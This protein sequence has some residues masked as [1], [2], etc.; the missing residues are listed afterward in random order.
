MGT[1]RLASGIDVEDTL[2]SDGTEVAKGTL[3]VIRWRGTLNRGD[4]FGSGEST[5]LAGSREIIAGLSQGVIGMRVGG[6]RK[7]RIGPHLAYRDEV[8]GSIP[9]NAVLNFGCY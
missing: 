8:V 9:P 2:V 5:F 7:I 3:V 4:E 6:K 1:M